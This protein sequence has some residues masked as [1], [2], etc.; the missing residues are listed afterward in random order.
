MDSFNIQT[1]QIY[2]THCGR[3]IS[4]QRLK[5]PAMKFV[6]ALVHIV[7]LN[8]TTMETN[9]QISTLIRARNPIAS[10][11]IFQHADCIELESLK[12]TTAMNKQHC[13]QNCVLL[14]WN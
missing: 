2:H 12:T 5:I 8:F 1:F 11:L 6:T 9:F 3:L 7:S 14:N 4:T 10:L 13:Y